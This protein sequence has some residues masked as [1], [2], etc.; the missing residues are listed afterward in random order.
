MP[1]QAN[2]NRK[3]HSNPHRSSL[4]HISKDHPTPIPP[5]PCDCV[6]VAD[7]RHNNTSPLAF[8]V[9]L[10]RISDSIRAD[11]QASKQ[12][13]HGERKPTH[14][15]ACCLDT[16]TSNDCS[17]T[18]TTI[19]RSTVTDGVQKKWLPLALFNSLLQPKGVAALY[20]QTTRIP[21]G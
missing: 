1:R 20:K 9:V 12:S 19:Q 11:K 2:P 18:A 7:N 17:C 8:V 4:S 21:I 13:K 16:P 5:V 15:P 6:S 14:L 10:L 3:L